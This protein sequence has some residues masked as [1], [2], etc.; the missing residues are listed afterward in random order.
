MSIYIYS[1]Y[2]EWL[3]LFNI[4]RILMINSNGLSNKE[5][6]EARKKYGSNG[7]LGKK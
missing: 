3:V 2:R 4:G 1:N 5:V 7:I 6:I